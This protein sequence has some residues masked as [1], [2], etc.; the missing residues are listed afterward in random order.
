M[1]FMRSFGIVIAAA[2][3]GEGLRALLTL[4]IPASVYGMLLML[5]GLATGLIKLN[6]V[7]PAATF[8][9][10][11]MPMLFIPA[12]AALPDVWPQLA[13]V[14]GPVAVTAVAVTLLVLAVTGWTAQAVIRW[15]R[16]RKPHG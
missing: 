9:L 4:P 12:M 8:L 10:E 2:F 7:K 14:F 1:A 5:A 11:I 16:R 13:P 6:Q 15:E 3:L